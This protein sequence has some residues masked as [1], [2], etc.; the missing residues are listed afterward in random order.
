MKKKLF[1]GIVALAII[2]FSACEKDL[3]SKVDGNALTSISKDGTGFLNEGFDKAATYL[4]K[5]GETTPTETGTYVAGLPVGGDGA[6]V[7][8]Y[9]VKAMS[10]ET[11]DAVYGSFC[12]YSRSQD[13]GGDA[14]AYYDK[15]AVRFAGDEFY[16]KQQLINAYDYILATYGNID[17]WLAFAG[18][19]PWGEEYADQFISK[20][21]CADWKVPT[22]YI[23]QIVTW[24]ILADDGIIP[25]DVKAKGPN[26][27]DEPLFAYINEI[28]DAAWAAGMNDDYVTTGN[29]VDLVFL[30]CTG[31]DY[32]N[33]NLA[34]QPQIVP[35]GKGKGKIEIEKTVNGIN[36]AVWGNFAG[37]L[38]F[39]LYKDGVK[40]NVEGVVPNANG[41][42]IFTDLADGEYTVVEVL[43]K[44][45][46]LI[47]EQAD[48]VTINIINGE[49][50]AGEGLNVGF[51]PKGSYITKG[52]GSDGWDCVQD[53][54]PGTHHTTYNFWLTDGTDRFLSFCGNQGSSG[55]GTV[56]KA[57]TVTQ[58]AE[59]VSVLNYIYKKF[60]SID[61]WSGYYGTVN[62]TDPTANTKLIAQYAIW[63][64]LDPAFVVTSGFDAIDA[65]V[66]DA[67]AN[68][69]TTIG[70]IDIYFMVGPNYPIDIDDIQ[71]Q[72]VPF[73][74]KTIFNNIE[75]PDFVVL[76]EL[77]WNNGNT[78]DKD[79]A[80]GAGIIS[81]KV[82]GVTFKNNKEYVTPANFDAKLVNGPGSNPNMFTVTERGVYYTPTYM[83]IYDIRVAMFV[84]DAWK[85]YAGS[86][87]VDNPGGND[88]NQIINLYPE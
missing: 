75:R 27:Y 46:K 29:V 7:N 77:N 1:L 64:V 38:S 30:A 85:V 10:G 31:Y 4:C 24:K 35:I 66:T 18:G 57:E 72:V 58:K 40:I 9:K 44:P 81:F 25:A 65:A 6:H 26:G 86:I 17:T 14:F 69:K 82:N 12:G 88:K 22:K 83:K 13:L 54:I 19:A 23:A 45:G 56:T 80:N 71:P 79:G 76:S 55:I 67:L 50:E 8:D 43:T 20:D 16:K 51:D 33:P 11:A 32:V 62:N 61:T 68:G 48:P 28:I 37:L 59:I 84:S 36:I 53:F 60:G 87:I 42:I 15:T 63:Q 74:S 78:S 41:M 73:Y 47:F 2:S 5:Y 34:C 3:I 39:D 21:D 49:M 52:N 70:I